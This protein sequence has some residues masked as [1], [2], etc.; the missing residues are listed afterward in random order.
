MKLNVQSNQQ[1]IHEAK[2]V[3]R[4]VPDLMVLTSTNDWENLVKHVDYIKYL[5]KSLSSGSFQLLQISLLKSEFF[6]FNVIHHLHRITNFQAIDFNSICIILECDPLQWLSGL[7]YKELYDQNLPIS[8][9]V[10]KYLDQTLKFPYIPTPFEVTENYTLGCEFMFKA[11]EAISNRDF[12]KFPLLLDTLKS[13]ENVLTFI[14]VKSSMSVD[15]NNLFTQVAQTFHFPSIRKM[16]EQFPVELQ[17]KIWNATLVMLKLATERSNDAAFKSEC[18]SIFNEMLFH[19]KSKNILD[20]VILPQ[21]RRIRSQ[22]V[23]SLNPIPTSPVPSNKKLL[24]N[25]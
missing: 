12:V 17:E 24:R 15:V 21:F 14:A 9:I 20:N 2:I 18:V 13:N 3:Y 23:N 11:Y 7:I 25:S 6:T 19:P 1:I 5:K 8:D 16:I 22:K 4:V 10:S